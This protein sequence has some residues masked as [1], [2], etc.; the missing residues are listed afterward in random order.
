[1]TYF[2]EWG[3]DYDTQKHLNTLEGLCSEFRISASDIPG[4]VLFAL[5]QYE[6]YRGSAIVVGRNI[7]G[8]LWMVEDAH[9]SCHGLEDWNPEPTTLK[10][11]RKL[12]PYS[13][14]HTYDVASRTAW[15]RMLDDLEH[16]SPAALSK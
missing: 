5:Y 15:Y 16:A 2:A 10:A 6:S 11:L 13:Y 12:N 3:Y 14:V 4:E 1:M 8:S 7:D 9:C